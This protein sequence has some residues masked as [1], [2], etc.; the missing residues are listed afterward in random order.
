MIINS[1]ID[2]RLVHGQ[3]ANLWSTQINVERFIILDDQVA[4]SAIDKSSLRLATPTGIRLSAIPIERVAKQINEGRYDS[5]RVMLLAKK[6]AAF[7]QLVEHGVNIEDLNVGNMSQ[8][9]NT[10]SITNSVNVTEADVADFR[11]LEEH[12][13]HLYTQMVPSDNREDFM[14]KLNKKF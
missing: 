8:S 7:V 10:T 12:G 5:Q 3:V 14:P 1:R 6:P 4:E 13:V 9:A 11:T 2:G